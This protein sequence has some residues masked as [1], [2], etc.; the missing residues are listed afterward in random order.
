MKIT[1]PE[2]L[3]KVGCYQ[4]HLLPSYHRLI[5]T[6]Y[7]QYFG[8]NRFRPINQRTA[9]G[10]IFVSMTYQHGIPYCAYPVIPLLDLNDCHSLMSCS[11]D[12]TLEITALSHDVSS[13]VMTNKMYP[14]CILKLHST[15]SFF[16]VIVSEKSHRSILEKTKFEFLNVNGCGIHYHSQVESVP[17]NKIYI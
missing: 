6:E 5:D 7:W 3:W 12:I 16:V 11:D 14:V 10:K 13:K 4:V 17:K 15:C 8:Y 9:T 1:E 2:V